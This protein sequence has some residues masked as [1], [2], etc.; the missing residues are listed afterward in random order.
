MLLIPDR[1]VYQLV[2]LNHVLILINTFPR[3]YVVIYELL[4]SCLSDDIL[5]VKVD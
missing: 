1:V 4:H 3:T 2:Q 5:R